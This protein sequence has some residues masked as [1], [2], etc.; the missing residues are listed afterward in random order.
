MAFAKQGTEKNNPI[1]FGK[2]LNS[3]YKSFL[4]LRFNVLYYIMHQHYVKQILASRRFH[5]KEVHIAELS[6]LIGFEKE[7]TSLLNSSLG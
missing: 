2:H 1:I 6:F 7:I 3:R 5:L 4:E